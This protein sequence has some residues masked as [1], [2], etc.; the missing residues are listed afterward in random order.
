MVS[1]NRLGSDNIPDPEFDQTCTA[2]FNH[3]MSGELPFK[4]AVSQLNSALQET[5]TTGQTANQARV[6]HLLANLQHHRGNLN[7]SIQHGERARNLYQQI[8]NIER[9]AIMD[10]NLG[11][12]YRYKGNFSRAITLYQTALEIANKTGNVRFQLYSLVNQ[13]L[14]YVA[15]EQDRLGR[16]NFENA[17][18]LLDS[19]PE[20]APHPSIQLCEI[21]HGM[22]VILLRA[23]NLPMAWDEARKALDI[24]Q[25]ER[26]PI[27]IGFANRTIGEV[28][29]Q[30]GSSPDPAYPSEPDEYFRAA[31]D[32]FREI[33][34][35]AELAR[36]MY[37]QAMSMA[38]RGNR[39]MAARK[40]Q[41]VMIMFTKLGMI[42]DAARAA[43][44]Q[45]KVI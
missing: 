9:V 5:I 16:Q 1:T 29:T 8:G 12:N 14:A 15:L 11:E 28:V 38:Q 45:L 32:A 7:A 35:E 34:A 40:L 18:R 36:T 4:E 17:L 31:S 21:H 6:E 22:A 43:E 25:R 23:A 19:W 37:S 44:A 33:N 30:M 42:D 27:Q 20:D 41:Q 13:G 3:W 24:A 26:L 10:M 39:T 2:I